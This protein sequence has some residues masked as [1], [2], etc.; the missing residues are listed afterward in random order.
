VIR[1]VIQK[2][3]ACAQIR[4]IC[5]CR[6]KFTSST[7]ISYHRSV[8]ITQIVSYA[9]DATVHSSILHETRGNYA[10]SRK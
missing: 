6:E 4:E 10:G 3:A 9:N 8:V 2:L 5:D 1:G 7:I